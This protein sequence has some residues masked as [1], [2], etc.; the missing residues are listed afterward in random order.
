VNLIDVAR[1]PSMAGRTHKYRK[2][3]GLH[4]QFTP[5]GGVTAS[6]RRESKKAGHTMADGS[7]PIN[8]AADLARAKHDVGRA[9]DPSAARSWINRRAKELGEP[10]L[11]GE[12]KRPADRRYGK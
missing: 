8:N 7:F 6:S 5:S 10:T 12:K 9:H 1:R 11:G 2:P 3:G 4:T